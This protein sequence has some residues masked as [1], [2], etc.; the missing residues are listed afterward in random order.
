MKKI[1]RH[2]KRWNYWR[3]RNTNGPL[4]QFLVLI[5]LHNSPTMNQVILKEEWDE[6]VAFSTDVTSFRMYSD[7]EE[8]K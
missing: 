3:K 1:I 7:E 4:H 2:F 8:A 5:G 6:L